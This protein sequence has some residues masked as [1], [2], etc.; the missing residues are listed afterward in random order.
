MSN[1]PE[2]EW[3]ILLGGGLYTSGHGIPRSELGSS[4]DRLAATAELFDN[5]KIKRIL[6]S[7]G[8]GIEHHSEARQTA[9]R[10]IAWGVPATALVIE[11]KSQNTIQNAQFSQPLIEGSDT[12]P[13]LLVT[14]AIHLPRARAIFCSQGIDVVGV[15]ANH[16]VRPF[17]AMHWQ[18]WIPSATSLSGSTR[19]LK[20]YLGIVYY[21]LTNRL[22]LDALNYDH[23]CVRSQA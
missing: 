6:I 16:W 21:A 20:E 18:D 14:S 3:A 12:S 13:S 4:G 22:R 23:S 15:A 17:A 10:L 9:D 2:T 8:A 1:I 5:K 11:E 7:S 19:A